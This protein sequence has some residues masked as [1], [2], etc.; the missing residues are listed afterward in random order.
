MTIFSASIRTTAARKYLGQL[1]KHFAHKV[2]V[3]HTSEEGRV[4]FPPG[5]CLMRADAETL[6][7]HCRA[8]DPGA[9]PVIQAILVDHVVKFA[10]RERLDIVWADGAPAAIEAVLAEAVFLAGPTRS[11]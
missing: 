1:C 8:R 10:W 9:V 5:R 7:F 11:P 6:S 3:E 4:E 2:A